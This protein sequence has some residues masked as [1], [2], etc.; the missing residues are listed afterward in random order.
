MKLSSSCPS[1][2]PG[3]D[4]VPAFT[5]INPKLHSRGELVGR[6]FIGH[7]L[8]D[9]CQVASVVS[10]SVRPHRRQP[11]R[12]SRPWDS[13]GKNTGVGFHFLLQCMKVKR[14]SEVA[15]VVSDSKRPHGLQPTRVL[16]PWDFLG[17]STGVGRHCLFLLC[18]NHHLISPHMAGAIIPF[19]DEKNKD[20][21]SSWFAYNYTIKAR[22]NTWTH[23]V[24]KLTCGFR[25][26]DV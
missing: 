19:S 20:L 5:S 14:E 9:C 7:L 13:P 26:Q 17:K 3:K 8:C 23:F 22:A 10:D 21:K 24:L 2:I 25:T 18:D 12:L 16:H 4:N 6:K 11:T 1:W 15:Q